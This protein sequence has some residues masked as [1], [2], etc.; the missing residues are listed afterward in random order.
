LRSFFFS[1]LIYATKIGPA[2]AWPDGCDRQVDGQEVVAHRAWRGRG[3]EKG[4]AQR[5]G[6]KA[7][8][9]RTAPACTEP[10]AL[11][12]SPGRRCR[13][14]PVFPSVSAGGDSS[15]RT[16]PSNPGGLRSHLPLKMFSWEMAFSK[17]EQVHPHWRMR[18]RPT[19][20][21]VLLC[22]L[23]HGGPLL[24]EAH[25]CGRSCLQARVSSSSLCCGAKLSP[26]H[27]GLHPSPRFEPKATDVTRKGTTA[28]AVETEEEEEEGWQRSPQ[29]AQGHLGCSLELFHGTKPQGLQGLLKSA[30][31]R[32]P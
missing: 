22:C 26:S 24:E 31:S 18:S 8:C 4:K 14:H 16:Q 11:A 1:L 5:F 9:G 30:M 19:A 13:H 17:E 25:Q 27:V 3:E 15:S 20:A 32:H 7:L 2:G 6:Q 28:P 10:Q 23:C 29:P 12:H 21:L